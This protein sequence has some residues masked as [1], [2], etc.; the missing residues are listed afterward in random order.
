[1]A[2]EQS[3]DMLHKS[4]EFKDKKVQCDITANVQ[5]W[6]ICHRMKSP[7]FKDKK[8]QCDIAANV[9][10]WLICHMMKWCT[11]I[12]V[13]LCSV[14]IT[15]YVYYAFH[16][17]FI[18]T[19]MDYVVSYDPWLYHE[20]MI[21][22]IQQQS[23]SGIYLMEYSTITQCIEGNYE[24]WH[25]EEHHVNQEFEPD[26]YSAYVY[27]N[28]MHEQLHGGGTIA[29]WLF[30]E[31]DKYAAKPYQYSMD[32]IFEYGAHVPREQLHRYAGGTLCCANIPLWL[33]S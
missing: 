8:V 30:S 16:E 32:D 4:S 19:D 2:T 3:T 26:S 20:N 13:V 22:G 11:F 9:Q 5:Q 15:C 18:Q 14:G 17:L 24:H 6:L 23:F 1:M 12:M 31:L 27:V 21:Y 29:T 10:Q 28:Y 33:L 7:E 25:Q